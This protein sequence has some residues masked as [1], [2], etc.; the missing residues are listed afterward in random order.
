MKREQLLL[1]AITERSWLGRLTMYQAAEQA[2]AGGATILQLRE[3]DMSEAALRAEIP[4]LL[5][6]CRRYN[7]P[8]ILDDHVALA[9]ELGCDGVHVGQNDMP[10]AE[11]RRILGPGKILGVTAKTVDQ[12]RAAQE[13]GADYLGS[14]AMFV[15]S[16]KPDALAMSADTLREIT[17]AVQ[18]PVVAI[19]GISARNALALSGCGIAGIAVS[20]AIFR[21]PDITAA[22]R[23]LSDISRRL[24]QEVT[25][26]TDQS[27]K[28]SS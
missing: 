20:E 9:A 11:A 14:G 28:R 3:K 19:G 24:T 6:L 2:L 7:V 8:F 26:G 1:Y 12:A 16:T 23:E 18:I 17:R 15:T 13:A 21:R 25:P 10:A 5:E 27:P 22:A 4:P